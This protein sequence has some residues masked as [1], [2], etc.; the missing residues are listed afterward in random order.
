MTFEIK[1]ESE[2]N[3]IGDYLEMRRKYD[4]NLQNNKSF[5]FFKYLAM[6]PFEHLQFY[7]D[8]FNIILNNTDVKRFYFKKF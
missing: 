7:F 2:L 1:F 6:F 8:T 4:Q 5:I 3:D